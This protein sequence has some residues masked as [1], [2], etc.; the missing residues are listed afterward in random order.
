MKQGLKVMKMYGIKII[1]ILIKFVCVCNIDVVTAYKGLLKEKEALEASFATL[2]VKPS[3]SRERPPSTEPQ[4]GQEN[5]SND[6]NAVHE[7][8]TTTSLPQQTD[9]DDVQVQLGTLMNSLATVS[10]EKSRQE[11][12]FQADKK[13]LRAEILIKDKI[14]QDLQEK[15]KLVH[16]K[17]NKDLETLKSKLIVEK[18]EREKETQDH[19][20]RVRE[21]Q[22]LLTDERHLKESLEMQ[23]NDLKTQFSQ[24]SNSDKT[25][26]EM[27]QELEAARRV[28]K[29]YENRRN[30]FN[31]DSA[32]MFQ[33]LQDEM[34]LLKQQHAV[35]IK[36]EQRRALLAEDTNRK[37]AAH[38]EERVASL[39]A[40]LSELSN[41]VG[42]YDRLR[43]QDQFNIA[44][45]KDKLARLSIVKHEEIK[46]VQHKKSDV[47]ALIDEILQLKKKL[48]MENSRTDCPI[49][50]SKIFV[51]QSDFD[52]IQEGNDEIISLAEHTKLKHE[53]ERLVEEN[54]TIKFSLEEQKVHI[55]TLQEK[56]KVLNRNIDEHEIELKNKQID[57]NQIIKLEKMKWKEALNSL[58][59][60][61]RSKISQLE[62]ELQKQRE[63]SLSLLEEK[64]KEIKTLK[65]SFEIFIPGNTQI[66]NSIQEQQYDKSSD[67]NV[68]GGNSDSEITFKNPASQLSNILN[69]KYQGNKSEPFHMLHYAHELAR[70]DVEITNL[71]KVKNSSET[72]LRQALHEKV[73]IQ[74]ELHDKISNLEDEVDRLKR[75]HSR[76]GANLEYLKN[77]I[78]SYLV[79]REE[80]SKKH[81]LNAIGAVLKFSPSEMNSISNYLNG[82]K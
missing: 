1:L 38:H 5:Q 19:M 77:V 33:K 54:E 49:D 78:L 70:K 23:L 59:G 45:L 63:R 37:L 57:F 62:N 36:N 32:S 64:E 69:T 26:K 28:V 18:H 75:Y 71:R 30:V 34:M 53:C 29:E 10:A 61:Y 60:E 44:K 20:V 79:T 67:N 12:S 2:T 73:T 56:V 76:E 42:T 74:E 14:I 82:K 39:E 55:K 47:S 43:Q 7:N 6:N 66:M 8:A 15:V 41:T 48:V 21:L 11:A 4:E 52:S 72:A 81:M 3:P 22:K 35:A 50:L 58:E 80:D 68:A 31:E 17:A 27:R 25:V 24:S 13:Q 51:M 65:T 40:R 46:V 9:S 16:N